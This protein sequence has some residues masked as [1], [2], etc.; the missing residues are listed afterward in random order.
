MKYFS[1]T[2]LVSEL[3]KKMKEDY[4][5]DNIFCQ[6]FPQLWGSTALGYNGIGGSAMTTADTIVIF[7]ENGPARVYFASNN[8]AYEIE[9]P[10]TLF[11][12]DI[13]NRNL[14]PQGEEH[15]YNN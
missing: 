11:W 6:V 2:E 9:N 14:R 12:K 13:Y 4:N 8:L 10:N 7:I 1:T 5:V 3:T 15:L